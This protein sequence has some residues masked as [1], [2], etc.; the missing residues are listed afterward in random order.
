MFYIFV[1]DAL[2]Q[3]TKIT[4]RESENAKASNISSQTSSRSKTE[5]NARYI[6]PTC[7]VYAKRP[8]IIRRITFVRAFF[9]TVKVRIGNIMPTVIIYLIQRFCAFLRLVLKRKR[10]IRSIY[11]YAVIIDGIARKIAVIVL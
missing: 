8:R 1:D 5:G 10:T 9:I 11:H 2:V 6:F 7:V 3:S 4:Y